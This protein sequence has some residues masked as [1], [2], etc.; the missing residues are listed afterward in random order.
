MCPTRR[1]TYPASCLVNCG[2]FCFRVQFLVFQTMDMRDIQG[3]P[4]QN[5]SVFEVPECG[6]PAKGQHPLSVKG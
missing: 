3:S 2:R 5:L 4:F 1:A 6:G